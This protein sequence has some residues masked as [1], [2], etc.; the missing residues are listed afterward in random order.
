[1][2]VKNSHKL[3]PKKRLPDS[4]PLLQEVKNAQQRVCIGII[5]ACCAAL[6]FGSAGLMVKLIQA[7]ALLVAGIRALIAGLSMGL[8]TRHARPPMK[9]RLGLFMLSFAITVWLFVSATQCTTAANAAWLQGASPAWVWL[10]GWGL[11]KGKQSQFFAPVVVILMGLMVALLSDE[12]GVPLSTHTAA[13]PIIKGYCSSP[14][15]GDLMGLLSGV[16]LAVMVLLLK[17]FNTNGRQALC[18]A[19]GFAAFLLLGT[20]FAQE[21]ATA[22]SLIV[23]LSRQDWLVLLFL[24]LMQQGLPYF[25]F[26]AAAS[27]LATGQ[28]SMLLLLEPITNPLWVWWIIGETPSLTAAMGGIIILLGLLLDAHLRMAGARTRYLQSRRAK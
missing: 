2:R 24:G 17:H 14:F 25:L 4:A 22:W 13:S 18:M 10:F 12:Q 20:L 27:R 3:D 1:M 26:A 28:L 8:I 19:N 6:M 23:Q 11:S 15:V 9:W 5:F 21:G 16:S 7:P